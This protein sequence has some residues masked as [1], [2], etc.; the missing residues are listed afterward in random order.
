ML[1]DFADRPRQRVDFEEG[2][3][4]VT[5]YEVLK[6]YEG[7]GLLLRF[8]PETGRTHQLRVHS[9]HPQGI[10][11]PISG[12]RLYGSHSDNSLRLLAESLAF[13]HPATSEALS[14]RLPF[15]AWAE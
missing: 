12:D 14:F 13:V 11:S 7:G 4:A 1:S 10:G 3:R 5:A 15:P 8:R 6:S 2:K 9:A